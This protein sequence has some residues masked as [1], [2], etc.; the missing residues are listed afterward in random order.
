MSLGDYEWWMAYGVNLSAHV[1]APLSHHNSFTK[2]KDNMIKN[3]RQWQ[4]IIK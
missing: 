2:Y 4:Q 3:F 1:H